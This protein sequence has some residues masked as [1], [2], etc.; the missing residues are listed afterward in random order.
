MTAIAETRASDTRSTYLYFGVLTFLV[1]L[2]SPGGYLVDITTSYMLKNQ[3]HEGATQVSIF[4]VLTAAPVYVAF[5]FGF[6]RDLWNPF[7]L[8]DRGYFMIFA[9]ISGAIFVLM[10]FTKLS[11]GGLFV[12]MLMVMLSR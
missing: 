3:L 8:K 2:S 1:Y 7:G 11:Y 12:G 10:A 6:A 4:R 5:L 9:P